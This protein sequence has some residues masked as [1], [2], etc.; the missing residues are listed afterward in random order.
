MSQPDEIDTTGMR[1]APWRTPA[2]GPVYFSYDDPGSLL[3][4]LADNA[5]DALTDNASVTLEFA[6][7]LLAESVQNTRELQYLVRTLCEALSDALRVAE[8]RGERLP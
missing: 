2:G 6:T 4:V 8:L 5:E 1:R 7:T 3:A